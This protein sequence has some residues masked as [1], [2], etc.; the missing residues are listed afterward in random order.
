MMCPDEYMVYDY[1]QIIL[2]Y[3]LKD[4]ENYCKDPNRDINLCQSMNI[5]IILCSLKN[6]KKNHL[7]V[8]Y[9]TLML[10][11]FKYRSKFINNMNV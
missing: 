4:N 1:Y 7:V 6:N 5:I 2:E 8:V 10:R 3:N 11:L 9:T